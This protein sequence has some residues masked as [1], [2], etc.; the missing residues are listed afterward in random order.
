MASTDDEHYLPPGRTKIERSG[1]NFHCH[2]GVECFLSC[3][4]N[5]DMLLF[6]YDIIRLKHRLRLHSSDFLHQYTQLSQGSHPYFPGLKLKLS[7]D[8]TLACPFLSAEGCSVY[9]D[10]PSACRTYPLE[11][12]V[13]QPGPGKALKVHYFLTHHPYCLG[14]QEGRSYTLKQWER[15]QKLFDYN[16]YNDLWAELD[17]F[18]A[19]NPWAGEGKAGP[20]Q[21]LA[22]M[23]C[24]NID[25]F[26]AY[27]DEHQ[28]LD[29]YKIAKDE[30]LRIAGS[31]DQ[32]LRF[33]FT[34]LEYVLGGR[35]N[36]VAR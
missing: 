35:R 27:V 30:R 19:T 18:F 4:R 7:N 10:R 29:S 5:V 36:L 22:F 20:Y 6:P 9:Q 26:R 17:A 1:F 14:H 33:G 25:G 21:Q 8:P 23:V 28:L 12:G 16:L 3:C 31:D 2:S 24:Y 13:E 11:R 15:D 32:L 34:W